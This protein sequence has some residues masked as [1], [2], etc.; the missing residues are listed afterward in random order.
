MHIDQTWR[1]VLNDLKG[2]SR[3]NERDYRRWLEPTRLLDLDGEAGKALVGAPDTFAVEN[4]DKKYKEMITA[5]LGVVTRRQ[6]AVEFRVLNGTFPGTAS[7]APAAS[8]ASQGNGPATA[9]KPVRAAPV[10]MRVHHPGGAPLPVQQLELGTVGSDGLNPRYLFST[11]VV[12]PS[13]RLA[14][15]ASL[16]VAENPGVVYNPLFIYGGVGLGKTHLMHAIGH[17]ARARHGTDLRVLYVSSE[18]I[19]QRADRLDP[20]RQ[21]GGVPR[22]L[23][24]ASIS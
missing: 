14:H 17:H 12:G 23:P 10:P 2:N 13:N 15:A 21:D 6:L 8:K 4:L 7:A 5:S 16:A 1:I 11:F 18:T 22:P 20:L 19:H 3:V 24:H 9:A